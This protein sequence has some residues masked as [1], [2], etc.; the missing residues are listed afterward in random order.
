MPTLW[1]EPFAAARGLKVSSRWDTND[2][3]AT[4]EGS[5]GEYAWKMGLGASLDTDYPSTISLTC[6]MP[7]TSSF[8]VS[9]GEVPSE[10]DLVISAVSMARKWW[11]Q[12]TDPSSAPPPGEPKKSKSR[13]TVEDPDGLLSPDLLDALEHWPES[14]HQRTALHPQQV[15]LLGGGIQS[16][17]MFATQG[18]W[19]E[20]VVAHHL[21]IAEQLVRR[22]SS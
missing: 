10:L 16:S 20:A 13:L 22:P 9:M 1:L 18:M 2:F 14:N 12:R 3:T 11:K 8:S 5:F 21:K 4:L 6:P 17:M 7:R 15:K 19:G